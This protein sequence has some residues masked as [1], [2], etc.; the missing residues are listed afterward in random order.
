MAPI[1]RISHF[2]RQWV[3]RLRVDPRDDGIARVKLRLADENL[4]QALIVT[5]EVGAVTKAVAPQ[6][7]LVIL[8]GALL[9][10]KQRTLDVI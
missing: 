1:E 6:E 8:F 2:A 10:A 5:K 3:L 4:A 7:D 9:D